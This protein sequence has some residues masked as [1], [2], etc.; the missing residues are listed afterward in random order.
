VWGRR[1]L[2]YEINKKT[3]GIYAVIDLQAGRY[4]WPYLTSLGAA[5]GA[6]G[7]TCSWPLPCVW[8]RSRS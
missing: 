7:G 3:E 8:P 6:T 2:V 5:T 1:R 4:S